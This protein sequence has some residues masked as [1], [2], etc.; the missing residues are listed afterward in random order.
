MEFT[1]H[2]AKSQLSKLINLA[3]NGEEVV[4]VRRGQPVVKLMAAAPRKRRLGW[5][6][7]PLP[8]TADAALR[9]LT[10]EETEAFLKGLHSW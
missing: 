3:R 8:D 6:P 7:I 4:I 1:V 9:A 10:D 5:D 2:E